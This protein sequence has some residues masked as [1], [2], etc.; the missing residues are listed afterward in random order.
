MILQF[1]VEFKE[2]Y[3]LLVSA[4]AFPFIKQQ[5]QLDLSPDCLSGYG[6]TL[7]KNYALLDEVRRMDPLYSHRTAARLS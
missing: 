5:G 2:Y 4:W 7:Y 1:G 6:K 3:E